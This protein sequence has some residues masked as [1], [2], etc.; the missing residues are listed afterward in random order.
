MTSP[1][2]NRNQWGAAI[3][4]FPGMVAFAF[5]VSTPTIAIPSIMA[6]LRADVDLGGIL[7]IVTRFPSSPTRSFPFPRKK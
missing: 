3:S 7:S 5:S 1:V 2:N 6:R 4:V